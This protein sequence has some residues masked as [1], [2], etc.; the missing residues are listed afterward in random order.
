MSMPSNRIEHISSSTMVAD[1]PQPLGESHDA[2]TLAVNENLDDDSNDNDFMHDS[3]DENSDSTEND[4]SLDDKN[5]IGPEHKA[6]E[7]S[8]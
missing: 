3:G 4:L 8:V 7:Q 2:E 5:N 1:K 6:L